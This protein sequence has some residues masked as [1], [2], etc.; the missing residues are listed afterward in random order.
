VD[1]RVG[2]VAFLFA[3]GPEVRAFLHSGLVER[4]AMRN[5]VLLISLEDLSEYGP[6]PEQAQ[7]EVLMISAVERKL[8]GKM[9]SLVLGSQTRLLKERGRGRWAH[10]LKWAESAPSR[11]SRGEKPH[12]L[13][14]ARLMYRAGVVAEK[15]L[16]RF[17][18]SH[19]FVRE[20]YRKWNV[21]MIVAS[22]YFSPRTLPFL[23]TARNTRRGIVVITNSWKDVYTTT[24]VPAMAARIVLNSTR[25]AS[26]LLDVN[27]HL[28][29]SRLSV[30]PSL[31][32]EPLFHNP[33][34]SRDEFCSSIGLDPMRPII[35]YSTASPQATKG[36]E[37][38]VGFLAEAISS[39]WIDGSPQ[40]LIR[41]NPME[42]KPGRFIDRLSDFSFVRF[43]RPKW[44][45]EPSR[46]WCAA[47]KE[48]VLL[49]RDTIAHSKI[50]VS[51][52]STVTLEFLMERKPVVNV[53]FDFPKPLA[54]AVSVRRFWNAEFYR[55]LVRHPSVHPA[56]SPEELVAQ[57]QQ[58]LKRAFLD[59]V[60][61]MTPV[62]RT[63]PT[64][65]IAEVIDWAL[66]GS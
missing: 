26:D 65:C 62:K 31:H 54:A 52:P 45:W 7:Q 9:R 43:Q 28:H 33:A 46:D 55:P 10:Y 18:G 38:T 59:D 50:N 21:R 61:E 15:S 24:H 11:S 58:A 44:S 22:S 16:A 1:E 30:C 64:V 47:Y 57:I 53:A 56:F 48:D 6:I 35:C 3:Y 60:N 49:W 27:P 40:L 5:R 12:N 2:T 42:D 63:S 25:A 14:G 39:G 29:A 23:Q 19:P 37:A 20:L 51:I 34:T 4:V 17:I 41:L 8:M 13:V 66:N 36:E 32:L